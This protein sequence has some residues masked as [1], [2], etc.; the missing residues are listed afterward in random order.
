MNLR[1]RP[2]AACLL[3]L[4]SAVMSCAARPETRS[5]ASSGAGGARA[6]G[7][8]AL[9]AQVEGLEARVRRLE[10]A[11]RQGALLWGGPAE[12]AAPAPAPYQAPSPPPSYPAPAP[13]AAAP[14]PAPATE[15]PAP[16]PER[17]MIL[18]TAT[19]SGAYASVA[20]RG[21][22]LLS[23]L[24]GKAS[25]PK[26]RRARM[27]QRDRDFQPTVLALPVGSTV[28]FP[29]ADPVYH[30]VFSLSPTK[31]FD[32]GVFKKGES[33]DVTFDQAGVVYVLCNLHASMS[34]YL[35]VHEEPYAA[36]VD[37]AGRFGFRDL[38][39]G[40]YRLRVWHERAGELAQRQVTLAAGQNRLQVALVA[41]Q[42]PTVPPNK[43]GKP[44]GAR[45][46]P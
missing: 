3:A 17:A 15:A 42:A 1:A 4:A 30:N 19:L 24:G 16:H 38:P 20:G 18:G 37:R 12:P 41:D 13:V 45:T 22:A 40:R 10:E 26:P 21:V 34:G 44:R 39:P 35:V 8:P 9:R 7:D 11:Q 25:A 2:P 28:S 31:K 33:R 14:G 5:D 43:E 36:L 29:N 32:L 46:A 23:P 6:D 27:E